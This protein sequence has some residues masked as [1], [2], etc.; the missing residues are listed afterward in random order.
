MTSTLEDNLQRAFGK[1][2][3]PLMQRITKEVERLNAWFEKNPQQVKEIANSIADALVKAFDMAK[4]IFG[5][6]VRHKELLLTMAKAFLVAKVA[7]GLAGMIGNTVSS[8]TSFGGA[9]SKLLG[10][11]GITAFATKLGLAG[12]ALGGFAMAAQGIA[13]HILEKQEKRINRISANPLLRE[14]ARLL[15]GS[16]A[17]RGTQISSNVVVGT[18]ERARKL[19]FKS[20]VGAIA[21]GTRGN[22]LLDIA[23]RQAALS[24]N[25]FTA[26]D[27]LLAHH[28]VRE[29]RRVG[30]LRKGGRGVNAARIA[31][32]FGVGDDFKS[33][34]VLN[35]AKSQAGG[36]KKFA[37]LSPT[38]MAQRL[39]EAN[40]G[41]GDGEVK[42][43]SEFLR[44]L[45][46]ALLLD[47]RTRA[48]KEA[49]R[50]RVFMS[51]FRSAMGADKEQRAVL[52][53]EMRKTWG[54]NMVDFQLVMQR[55]ERSWMGVLRGLGEFAQ[56]KLKEAGK[57]PES[58]AKD[59]G[60]VRG[61]R[62]TNVKISK[63]EV[64]SDDPDRFAFNLVGAF[65]D[66]VKSP[67]QAAKA[68][69]EG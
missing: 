29:S 8:I 67:T 60:K 51:E 68:I 5:F 2:G 69:R 26:G 66:Y 56:M 40:K 37:Q 32:N 65:Q 30:F 14:Q 63:I 50:R 28:V 42:R 53:S 6:I 12:A 18:E 44:G 25:K 64:V 34:T 1:I 7:G 39:E 58:V 59:R 38:E 36:K 55:Q 20:D 11:G 27:K 23:R 46:R 22:K 9:I 33:N 10:K 48:E 61:K 4:R 52:L 31:G 15:G 35:L 45:D 49:E 54:D 19:G 62:T 3:L 17:G 21:A 16:M 57:E 41:F 24:Q 13:N 47:Q 43:M